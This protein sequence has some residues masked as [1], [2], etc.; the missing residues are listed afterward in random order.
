[1]SEEILE[2][3]DTQ[4]DK[5]LTFFLGEETYGIDIRVV[6]MDEARSCAG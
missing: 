3:E 5:Y 1:M 6:M 4:K 2:E